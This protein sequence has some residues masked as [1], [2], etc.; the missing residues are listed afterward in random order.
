MRATRSR[1]EILRG[2]YQRHGYM[3]AQLL[4]DEAETPDGLAYELHHAFE[5]DD[6]LAGPLYRRVQAA[7]IIR[8]VKYTIVG[9][10]D[11]PATRLRAWQHIPAAQIDSDEEDPTSGSYLPQD[12]VAANPRL[13]EIARRDMERRWKEL[14]RTYQEHA[15]FWSMVRQ[16][17][18]KVA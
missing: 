9:D 6:S 12:E 8:S 5:W 7:Q 3:S 4:V 15:E 16:D 10:G 14:R 2:V 17:A 18:S 11:K 1:D 13:A